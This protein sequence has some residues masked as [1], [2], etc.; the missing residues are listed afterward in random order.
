MKHAHFITF[1]LT[2]IT[3]KDKTNFSIIWNSNSRHFSDVGVFDEGKKSRHT[4][5]HIKISKRHIQLRIGCWICLKFSKLVWANALFTYKTYNAEANRIN[6]NKNEKEK[7]L[8]CTVMVPPGSKIERI[9]CV[10]HCLV[11]NVYLFW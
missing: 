10:C 2:T 6:K 11:W 5:A 4:H 9:H 3:R 7:I 8:Y 1:Y